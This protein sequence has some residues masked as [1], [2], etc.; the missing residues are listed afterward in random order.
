MKNTML[1][2]T[3]LALVGCSTLRQ[4]EVRADASVQ[5]GGGT[6]YGANGHDYGGGHVGRV[7]IIVPVYQLQGFTLYSSLSHESLL[8]TSHDRGE[9]RARVGFTWRPLQ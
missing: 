1:M 6:H 9:E 5:V 7:E 8:D 4:T 2:L 3:T